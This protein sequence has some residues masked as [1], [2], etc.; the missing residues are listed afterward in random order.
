MIFDEGSLTVL[1][2][3]AVQT[4]AVFVE[5][6]PASFLAGHIRSLTGTRSITSIGIGASGP[7]DAS[8]I[9][10]NPDTLGSFT[11]API[12]SDLGNA[13]G[14]AV[15]I[16]NDAVCAAIAEQRIG[17]AVNASSL[18]HITLGTGIGACLLVN[19]SPVRG[20]DGFHPEMGHISVRTPDTSCYCGRE[21]C[22]EQAASRQA[23]QRTAARILRKDPSQHGLIAEL[24]RRAEANDTVAQE[25]FDEY[26][27][28]V[29]E[30]LG[31]LLAVHRPEH[32][33]LGGSASE[34]FG[35]FSRSLTQ[36][37]AALG[38]WI[39]YRT[40]ASTTL[41][42]F[43]GAIGAAFLKPNSTATQH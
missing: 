28:A 10:Q 20:G 41:D 30:G 24:A 37:L 36:S 11:G 39:H 33:V 27:V 26:G 12:V 25:V 8:G 18:L 35:L 3:R 34:H 15:H 22:W 6:T 1:D 23:L 31:T 14:V 42:D 16:D 9:I 40:L 21:T 19:G 29:A 13:F 2:R 5:E 43:G 4:P 32:V 7:V 17:A 38:P